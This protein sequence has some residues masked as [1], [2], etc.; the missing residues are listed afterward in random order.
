MSGWMRRLMSNARPD[1]MR[2][3]ALLGLVIAVSLMQV[4]K[5]WPIKIAID[6]VLRGKTLEGGLSWITRLPRAT[7][8]A[9]QLAWLAAFSVFIFVIV[10]GLTGVKK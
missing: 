2:L 4:A 3:L 9:G 8:A 6:Y 10:Q 7:D 1:R 5:P